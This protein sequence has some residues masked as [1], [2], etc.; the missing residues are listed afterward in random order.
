[1]KYIELPITAVYAQSPEDEIK[2]IIHEKEPTEFNSTLLIC[3]EDISYAIGSDNGCST[4]Y[5]Q[6]GKTLVVNIP[7]GKLAEQLN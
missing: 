6:N 3:V 7:I 4:L 5:L 2:R 1:M